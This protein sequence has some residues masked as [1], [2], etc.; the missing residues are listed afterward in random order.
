MEGT[1]VL[2]MLSSKALR[3][4][5]LA[6]ALVVLALA[7]WSGWVAWQV[8]KDLSEA[9]DRT[10]AIRDAVTE[11]DSA[12][13]ELEL[14]EL[15]SASHAAAEGTSGLTW[16]VLSA[17]PLIG[18]D[19]EAVEV[20]SNVLA[21]L[22]DDGV[23][24]LV[25]VSDRLSD[26]LPRDGAI[27]LAE[28]AA[29]QAP[30]AEAHAAFED[31]RRELDA[32]DP[33]GYV[34]RLREQFTEFR[35]QVR[36]ADRAMAAAE[37]TSSLLPSMLGGEGQRS[38]LVGFQNNAEIRGTAGLIGAVARVEANEG[39]LSIREQVSGG[40]VT[41][42]RTTSVP[43][44]DAEDALYGE[45]LGRYFANAGMTPDV[46]RVADLMRT[47]WQNANPGQAVDGV[48]LVDTVAMAYLLDATGPITVD[49]I[50]LTSD[51]LVDELL[52]NTYLRLEGD[53]AAQD[54]FF[55]QVAGATFDR[56]TGDI[57]NG[58]AIIDALGRATS[59][60][61][62]RM[63]SFDDR[64]QA[65]IEGSQIAGEL[66]TDPGQPEP[67]VAVTLNDRTG[68]KMS[69]YLRYDVDVSATYCADGVQGFAAKARLRST[70]PPEAVQFP[71]DITGGGNYGIAPGTQVV[72]VRIFGPAGGSIG[73][74][75]LNA[76]VTDVTRVDQDGRPVAM[77]Y[78]E[79]APGQTVDLAWTMR[80][81]HGQSGDADLAVTP[82]LEP[83][84][85]TTTVS[86][87][88]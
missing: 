56:L 24:P 27:D 23:E 11:G 65:E 32:Q 74:V 51:N 25:E 12:A 20:S 87:A 73:D 46:P 29:L 84:D 69:Y 59:E 30:I 43:L 62:L 17:L 31:A 13:V 14:A 34:G 82:T 63:H 80:S 78:V 2:L 50:E 1:Y 55:A 19:A 81:G 45:A 39:G 52:N 28:V 4:A 88:C 44:T 54:E 79:L 5:L 38:Y 8:N 40:S 72:I 57:D 6:L 37:T 70:A 22:S 85:T 33:S 67:Q 9:V 77:A 21:D 83:V 60:G 71:E 3:Y 7:A 41:S 75:E 47:H 35:G 53:G 86:T 68:S 18:D 15:Q 16:T 66:P 26:L 48:V 61:R 42:G 36:Q 49:G 64:E 10:N 76:R 58:E